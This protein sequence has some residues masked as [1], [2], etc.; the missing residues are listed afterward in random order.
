MAETGRVTGFTGL[1]HVHCLPELLHGKK[2]GNHYNWW[3]KQGFPRI[4]P[5][6]QPSEAEDLFQGS[7][8]VILTLLRFPMCADN[9]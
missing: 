4:F 2:I 7:V 8:T 1:V 3:L 5:I 9:I 6:N